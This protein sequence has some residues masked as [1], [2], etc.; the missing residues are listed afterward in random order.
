M[1]A[2]IRWATSNSAIVPVILIRLSVGLIFL[3]EG[4]QKFL[5]SQ[6][7]A[8]G[9]FEKIGLPNPEFLGPFVGAFEIACGGL[10][11]LGL[12]TRLASI[13]LIIV[14]L[15]AICTTKVPILLNDGFWKMAHESRTDF[16]MFL[17]LIFLFIVGSGKYSLDQTI[18]KQ[19]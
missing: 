15:T 5:F 16:A 2:W 14:M 19:K 7:L 17:S 13:P 11:L 10:I 18:G 1:K 12:L 3:S 4:I 6:S 8:V 9:R